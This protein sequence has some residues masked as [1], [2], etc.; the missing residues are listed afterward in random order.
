MATRKEHGPRHQRPAETAAPTV[1]N[2]SITD[3]G[4]AAP[5]S[6]KL[7]VR[8]NPD[9]LAAAS[10]RLGLESPADVVNTSLTLAAKPDPFKTWL[11]E[12]EDRLPDNFELAV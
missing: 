10:K 2:S 3:S 4:L 12:T 9:V 1:R 7:S 8:V 6:R 5:R 11:A